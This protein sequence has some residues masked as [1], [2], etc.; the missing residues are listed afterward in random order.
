MNSTTTKYGTALWLLL[1]IFACTH[2]EYAHFQDFKLFMAQEHRIDLSQT[3]DQIYYVIPVSSCNTCSSTTLNLEL[4][5]SKRHQSHKNQLTVILTG[6]INEPTHLKT[7]NQ[8]DA[9]YNLIR[10]IGNRIE[11]YQTGISKPMLLHIQNGKVKRYFKIND[12]DIEA[13]GK[14]LESTLTTG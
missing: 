11:Q 2:Q 9:S 10:D 14:Y 8:L 1:S 13:V 5:D 7:I 4:L 3:T 6:K 12:P